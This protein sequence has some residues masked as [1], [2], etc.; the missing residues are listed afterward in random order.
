MNSLY[1]SFAIT[2]KSKEALKP[3]GLID[4]YLKVLRVPDTGLSAMV[5]ILGALSPLVW[6]FPQ[7]AQ[8]DG[9]RGLAQN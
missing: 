3:S 5:N 2:S 6:A 1:R 7:H 8:H 4:R 9:M